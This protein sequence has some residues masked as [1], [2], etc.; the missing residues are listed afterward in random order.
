MMTSHPTTRER[1]HQGL[2]NFAIISR[3]GDLPASGSIERQKVSPLQECLNVALLK[4]PIILEVAI[5][6]AM[7]ASCGLA[8][9]DRTPFQ[10]TLIG[11]LRERRFNVCA[12]E[13]SL[14]NGMRLHP[15]P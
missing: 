11:Y 8:I 12:S 15:Q 10:V 4:S 9:R 2:R 3:L 5:V 13:G 7:G 6:A 14:P 1:N